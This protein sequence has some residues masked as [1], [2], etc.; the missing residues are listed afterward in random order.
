MKPSIALVAAVAT[1]L[2]LSSCTSS[3]TDGNTD[4][5]HGGES[6]AAA[7]SD[8][9][10]PNNAADVTFVSGMIPHHQQALDMAGLVPQRSSDPAVI[11]LASDIS[12]AQ[13]PEIK[14]MKA[15]LVQWTSGTDTG[16]EGH[17]MAGMEM[18]GMV[19]DATMTRLGTLKGAEFDKLWLQ[20]MIGHH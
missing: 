11:K 2:L 9:P 10:A 16:H 8:S 14:T 13:D 1:T 18:Q 3:A 17:D 4:H 7:A 12:A 20:S 19:D 5:A 6:S 15:F